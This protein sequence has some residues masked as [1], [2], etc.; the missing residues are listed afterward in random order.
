MRLG[1][2]EVGVRRPDG[3]R[4]VPP[5][6]ALA[7][8]GVAATVLYALDVAAVAGFVVVGIGG[9]A[10]M[11]VG[12]RRHRVRPRMPWHLLTAAASLFLVGALIRPM[13]AT[14]TGA[15]VLLAD[16][17]TLVGFL[18]IIASLASFLEAR[19]GI[20]RHALIDG[21]IV[22]IGAAVASTLLFALPAASIPG[23]P[24]IVSVLSG[25]FPLFDAILLLLV[26]NLAF[27]GA[28]RYPSFLLLLSMMV[29][30]FAGDIAYAVIGA[31]GQLYGNRLLDLPFLMAYAMGGA[32]ALHPS[33]RELVRPAGPGAQGWSLPRLLV[34]GPAVAVPFVLTVALPE[35]SDVE[36]IILGVGG[37]AI[38]LLLI[39]R[40][41]S[42]VQS[43]AASQRRYEYQ[44]THDPLTG[45]P[46]RRMLTNA[47]D[48]LL[49]A[50]RSGGSGRNG[51][52]AQVWVYFLDLDGFKWVND[53]WGHPA[54]DQ[55]IVDIGE[56]LRRTL[57]SSATVARLGGDEFIV[58]RR[59]TEDEAM[60][61][62]QEIMDCVEQPLWVHSV[63]VVITAS[64]G[65]ASAGPSPD[66]DV[67]AESL[68][69]DAD[70]AMYRTKAQARGTWTV[71]DASMRE[72]VQERIQIEVA[73][74][75][76]VA[77]EQ[78]EVAYQPI[79]DLASGRPM[80]AEALVR[81]AHP[82][83]GPISPTVFIPIAEDSNLI[84]LLGAWVLRRSVRQFA[85]WRA[86]GVVDE[87]F[88]ISIN[89][90]PR[91]LSDGGFAAKV[92]AELRDAGVPASRVVLEITESVMVE[93]GGAT[94]TLLRE[95]REL[96][97]GIAVDDFGTGF[98]A[99]GYLRS[100]PVTGVKIDRSFVAGLGKNAEDE[101]I[102]RAVVAM[103]TALALSVVAEGVETADQRAVLAGLGVTLAQGWLWGHAIDPQS[104]AETWSTTAVGFAADG[105]TLGG[106]GSANGRE[107]GAR[108]VDVTADPLDQ[109]VGN[110]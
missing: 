48:R 69:R 35:A 8:G 36:R 88:F 26:V 106:T 57:P 31:T 107:P 29:L 5:W 58:V 21:L 4:A 42:A 83:R 30:V 27:T 101:E 85:A 37:A 104:F 87:E 109:V 102:V 70:T 80:G 38:V 53:S 65:I 95:L 6:L 15:S 100:H 43:H 61:L 97:V 12:P 45:L 24:I 86:T 11:V 63:E 49:S 108:V 2:A 22:C 47:V 71:F 79:V 73:L 39:V 9:V 54:G 68:M 60:A 98:S 76:A 16:A 99:L 94:E 89:V 55:L 74:R 75:A 92:A 3:L 13:V 17:F 28:V 25:L 66:R 10:A 96:G 40:A 103:S 1:S 33:A 7:G 62:A 56:R 20:E 64:M 41:V 93:G 82:T 105:A 67:S 52:G 50:E 51:D 77:Q 14:A 78:L 18:A 23:R 81:W 32:A 72:A 59:C 110:S 19:N 90:S 44:A 34:I 91:Q 46:N 84:S